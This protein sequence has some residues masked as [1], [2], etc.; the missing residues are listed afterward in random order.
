M[1]PSFVVTKSAASQGINVHA[2]TVSLPT[3]ADVLVKFYLS[4]INPL[5]LAVIAGAYP[6]KPHFEHDGESILGFDAIGEVV[7]LG[8]N[9]KH[10]Q[11]GDF[12]V[13]AKYGIGTWRSHA[14]IDETLLDKIPKPTD[15]RFGAI[16]RLGVTPAYFLVEG[17][18]KLR[19]GDWIIQ[20]AGTS[21][22]AQMVVQFAR[23]RGIRVLSVIRDRQNA[24]S[25]IETLSA[26]PVGISVTGSMVVTESQLDQAKLDKKFAMAIDSVGGF[27]GQ[28]ILACLT[29]GGTFVQHGFLSGT[30]QILPMSAASFWV[31]H[32]TM[33]SSRSSAQMAALTE[34]ERRYLFA[35]FVELF[36]RG[37]LQ[38]PGLGLQEIAFGT[39]NT[40]DSRKQLELAVSRAKK[41][42]LG[43]RKQVIVWG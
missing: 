38:L 37:D 27:S 32:L 23:R 36:N 8:P 41:G 40:E 20:N 5:D 22:V 30:E 2:T 26:T 11:V 17:M 33:V 13:P 12:V 10:L 14:L 1:D 7:S 28:Q 24:S 25:T 3:D 39:G 16:L 34:D 15:L 18:C 19:P 29:T 43:Q 6:V 21:V 42:K 9:V 4:P 35:W 31:R